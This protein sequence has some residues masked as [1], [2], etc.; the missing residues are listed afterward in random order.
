MKIQILGTGC[1]NIRAYSAK[2]RRKSSKNAPEKGGEATFAEEPGQGR[3]A[4]KVVAAFPAQ[5]SGAG[6]SGLEVAHAHIVGTVFK[7]VAAGAF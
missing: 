7:S 3:V 6:N 4:T 5:R 1:R 2:N